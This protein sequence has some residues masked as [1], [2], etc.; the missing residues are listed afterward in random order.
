LTA[1]AGDKSPETVALRKKISEGCEKLIW[2]F[3]EGGGQVVIYD[4]NNGTT[5][6]RNAIAER[7][8]KAGIHVVMLGMPSFHEPGGLV[9]TFP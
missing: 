5:A 7:F 3:F 8:D 4:A 2:D 6:V 9:S 1:F